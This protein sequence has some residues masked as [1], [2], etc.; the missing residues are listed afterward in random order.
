MEFNR[1][2]L[3]KVFQILYVLSVIINRRLWFIFDF[4]LFLN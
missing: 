4:I 3:V 1:E 2:N